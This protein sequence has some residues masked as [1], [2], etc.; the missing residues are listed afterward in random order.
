MELARYVLRKVV[1]QKLYKTN[2]QPPIRH[3][4][5]KP[6]IEQIVCQSK[7]NDSSKSSIIQETKITN[8][9]NMI[10]DAIG[11]TD[12]LTSFIGL[13]REFAC[14]ST[15][16]HPY[17]DKLKRVQM[18]LFDLNHAISRSKL[19]KPSLFEIK[20]TQ[21]LE[22]W[23]SEYANQLPPPE[24]YIIPGGGKA[25]ASLHVAK[26]ICK[27]A[28]RNVTA[29][30]HKGVIDKQA[31]IYLSRLSEFLFTVSRIAAKCDQRTENIY[32]PRAEV[33]DEK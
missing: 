8:D 17:L 28:E 11:T 32:I 7:K 31:Q 12:E 2:L 27:R 19:N 30:V 4:G 13:A 3:S 1:I 21:D 20:H 26:A 10:D 33:K 22:E 5:N 16:E 14:G 6:N 25:C 18:I 9:D 23:I 29:L 15:V 24:D